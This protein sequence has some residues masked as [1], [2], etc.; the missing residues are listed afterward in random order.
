MKSPLRLKDVGLV[1]I[2]IEGLRDIICNHSSPEPPD[3]RTFKPACVFLLIF[4]L[5]E[6]H[7]LAIQKADSEG[8]PW[9][10]QV[11][12]PGGHLDAEDI[13]PLDGA[14]R[15]LEE[16]MGIRRDQVEFIGS[17]G[18]FQTIN[19]RDIEVF[20]GMWKAGGPMRPDPAEISRILKIP[21]RELVQTHNTNNF[22]GRIPDVDELR[23]PF[24]DVVIWGATA[25]ILHHFIELLLEVVT[26]D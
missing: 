11:A 2:D 16:E 26:I 19:N 17:L 3:N 7:I 12:L 15:E 23:Y 13:S 22:N 25:R 21:L 20:T 1:D 10:N 4:D 9:R 6:P 18:H 8:Y 5:E 14:F 24:E